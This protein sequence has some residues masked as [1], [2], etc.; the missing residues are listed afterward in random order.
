MGS[1]RLIREGVGTLSNVTLD[2]L[3]AHKLKNFIKECSLN[4]NDR[5]PPTRELAEKYSVQ[6]ITVTEALK[7]LVNEGVLYAVERKGYFVA[8]EKVEIDLGKENPFEQLEVL[9]KI[10]RNKGSSGYEI[11]KIYGLPDA[12]L[13]F[14]SSILYVNKNEKVNGEELKALPQYS[15]FSYLKAKLGKENI[16][17]ANQLT[18]PILQSSNG[19]ILEFLGSCTPIMLTQNIFDR[20]NKVLGYTS[21]I[22][23]GERCI[24]KNI[25][26]R[27]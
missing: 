26:N 12:P 15:L 19:E 4:Y 24:L 1:L 3:L 23:K 17:S 2:I 20:E 21:L 7:R 13:V 27:S 6:R 9:L 5:L 10:S 22:F 11:K 25:L 16:Y 18:M 8:P 14:E